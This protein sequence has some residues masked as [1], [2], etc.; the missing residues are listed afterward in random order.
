MVRRL[1][2]GF[3]I[4]LC[5]W[6]LAV[7]FVVW[8]ASAVEG[9]L[10]RVTATRFTA[11][12]VTTP[13]T[14][15]PQAIAADGQ[16]WIRHA[17]ALAETGAWRLRTTDL[18]NAPAGRDVYW[19]SGW[20][21]WLEACGR[22]R[23]ACTGEPLPLAIELA[24][25]WAQL[26]VLVLVITLAAVW[27]GR[28][29]GGGAAALTAVALAGHRGFYEGFYPAYCDHHGLINAAVLGLVL[30]AVLAGA[31]WWQRRPG[32]DFSPLP[33]SEA[34]V[35]RAATFSAVAGALGLWVSAAS[36]V[37]PIALTGLG[38]LAAALCCGR[39][40]DANLVCVPLAW[41]R[42]GQVG[43]WVSLGLY[44]LENAPDRLGMRLEANHPLYSLAWC[45]GGE[46]IAAVLVWRNQQRSVAWLAPRL[47][48]W[49]TLVLA[50]PVFVW[51]KGT[52]VFL[53]LDP[54][55]LRIHSS[56]DEF[57]PLL[58]AATRTG[59]SM[60]ADQVFISAVAGVVLAVWG[61]RK[62]SA[63]QRIVVT[64]AAI[65]AL[66][67]TA[68]GWFQ[69]RWL[70]PSSGPQ[71]VLLILVLVALVAP[72]HRL[73]RAAVLLTVGALLFVPGPWL[74]TSDRL[75]VQRAN[76]VQIGET[77][78]LLYRDMAEA[79][80]KAGADERSV[81]LASPNASVGVG[82]YGRLRSVGTLYWEN[83][84]G[85][86]TAAEVFGARDEAEAEARIKAAGITHV[87]LV[88]S[89]DFLPE[90]A[91]ALDGV[92]LTA[93][94]GR[95]RFGARL[96]Y[97]HRVP[98]WLRPLPYRVPAPLAPLGFQVALFAVDFSTAPAVSH[99]RIGRYQLSQGKRD[100]AEASFLASLAADASRPEAW[101]R[102]GE[103]LLARGRLAE[104]SRFIRAGIDR[105]PAEQ[106]DRLLRAAA[107]LLARQGP[108]GQAEA[109]R[110][111]G[112]PAQ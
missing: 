8:H 100:L 47:L 7:G 98:V 48:G 62:P 26:P 101:L 23:R 92:Q 103:V 12:P 30:G 53:P 24:S 56:I 32:A 111:L 6:L 20:A 9:Y 60:Y 25:R 99:E 57:E 42:W 1:S 45:A 88:S 106:R 79:L 51:A 94:A 78:Q 84:A 27:V 33:D 75:R 71:I 3:G 52:S 39:S 2:R 38:V 69:R 104:A 46:F 65:V 16:V 37:V 85:L 97:Q 49:G 74:L 64:L 13:L 72:L 59:W 86:K 90:Y 44:L 58:T 5:G 81:V 11:A 68:Q 83:R 17:L 107:A 61:W 10:T 34:V 14:C 77:M 21:L 43:A 55:L 15:V 96:L 67:L 29:W 102:Q 22:V 105:A 35:M 40:S 31:G 70:L 80:R 108:A 41:R 19:N 63:A 50:A 4:G 28:R 109:E 76:D 112:L 89:Y 110:L 82:Y 87:A 54:F 73:W 91:Y 36:L 95:E 93:E 66:T 18:D